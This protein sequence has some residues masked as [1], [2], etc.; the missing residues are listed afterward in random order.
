MNKHKEIWIHNQIKVYKNA[1]NIAYRKSNK[2]K[3]EEY[4]KELKRLEKLLKNQES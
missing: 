1:L 4:M 3:Q 2:E